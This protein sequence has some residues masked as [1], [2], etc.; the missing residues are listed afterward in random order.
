M[1]ILALEHE[2][3]TATPD[4]FQR[5]AREEACAA[6][7]MHQAGVIRELYFRTDQSTA[8]FMLECVSIDEA[9]NTL[10]RLPF[11]REGLIKF[12]L[13]PL[14]AYPGFSRLFKESESA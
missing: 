10:A 3:E 13:I 12:E 1:K 14:K 6:W 2:R 8:V 11:V 7:N 9:S 5:F 4:E